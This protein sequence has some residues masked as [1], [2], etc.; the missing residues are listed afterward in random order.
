MR[1]IE[2]L[3]TGEIYHVY[4][5][6]VAKQALFHD[7]HDYRYFLDA[8]SYY[9]EE[10]T[11]LRFSM[12]PDEVRFG[13]SRSMPEQPL[14]KVL[15]YCL[16]P[17]HF[18]FVLQQLQDDGVTHCLR[19]ALNSYTRAY[20]TR[21]RRVGPL[22]QGRFQAKR[23]EDDEQLLHLTRYVHLNPLMAKLTESAEQYR[24]SSM[25]AYLKKERHRLCQPDLVLAMLHTPNAYREF[26]D[27][28]I[29]FARELEVI[30]KLIKDD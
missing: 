3:T 28:Y 2:A 4:N 25:D 6:G 15:A 29:G 19:K 27:D 26:I 16:M 5:R 7:N 1:R 10:S 30:K 12:L 8:L 11:T 13:L 18:H 24:W 20:N 23:V 21:H 17:N 14:V 22:F 9:L